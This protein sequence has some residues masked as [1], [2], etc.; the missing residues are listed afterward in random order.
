MGVFGKLFGKY[1]LVTNTVSCGVMMGFGDVLQQRGDHWKRHAFPKYFESDKEEARSLDN[2][3]NLVTE[4]IQIRS[5][6]QDEANSSIEKTFTII[7]N[8][9]D[10][11]KNYGHDYVRTKNMCAVGLVQGP[12]HHYFYAILDRFLPGR[13]TSSVV[14]KTLVD[15]LVA[16]PTCL[17]IFFF[18]LG[19]LEQRKV[20]DISGEVKLK[21][22]D[23]YKVDCFFWP[24]TQFVNFLF[25]PVQYRVVYINLMTMF[26]DIFLSYMKYDAA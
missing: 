22:F 4:A 2:D 11:N 3:G 8:D 16:S 15:Q 9:S 23:T 19:A 24:P 1:L 12:F 7:E 20:E 25:V 21:F 13:N 6:N 18:G 14:K 26:Y 5:N 10:E 17:G